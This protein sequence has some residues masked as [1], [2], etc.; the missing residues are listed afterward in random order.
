MEIGF[1][2]NLTVGHQQCVLSLLELV[3][4]REIPA[5]VS[6]I[7]CRISNGRVWC[8]AGVIWL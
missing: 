7:I 2:I 8:G 1:E 6:S 4:S 5:C 3:K